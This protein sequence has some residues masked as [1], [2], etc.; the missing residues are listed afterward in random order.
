MRA[1][2]VAAAILA[3]ALSLTAC[4]SGTPGGER[5][6]GTGSGSPTV[7]PGPGSAGTDAATDPSGSTTAGP[8]GSATVSE[9]LVLH[10][11]VSLPVASGGTVDVVAVGETDPDATVPTL[12]LVVHNNT[13]APVYSVTVRALGATADG[14]PA[15]TYISGP[16]SP[17]VLQPGEWAYTEAIYLEGTAVTGALYTYEVLYG[18]SI[19]AIMPV[20]LPLAGV[21]PAPGAVTGTVSNP[22]DADVAGPVS[23]TV[24]CFDAAGTTPTGSFATYPGTDGIGAGESID[25]TVTSEGDCPTFAAAGS[26]WNF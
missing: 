4:A 15:A 5:T 21:T 26:G 14:S 13:D 17:T 12:P 1:G 25:F 6:R 22:S 24:M 16:F 19:G 11:T 3:A 20:D 2:R 8:T 18:E 7:V 9:Y 10:G 23:V